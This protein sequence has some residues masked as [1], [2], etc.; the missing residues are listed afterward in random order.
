MIYYWSS[1]NSNDSVLWREEDGNFRIHEW[2]KMNPL[3]I[4]FDYTLINSKY[5]HLFENLPGDQIELSPVI[6]TRKA[7]GEVWNNYLELIIKKE[8]NPETIHL[9]TPKGMQI[10][11][12]NHS[13]FVSEELMVKIEKVN[14]GE[15]RFSLG[16]SEWA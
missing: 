14:T 7:T 12:F 16:F 11:A 3:L 4:R 1:A 13:P 10:W 6:I 15:F 2:G 5:A 8:I 9:I